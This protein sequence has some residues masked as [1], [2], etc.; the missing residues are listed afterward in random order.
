MKRLKKRRIILAISFLILIVLLMYYEKTTKTDNVQIPKVVQDAQTT[1]HQ[2]I[3]QNDYSIKETNRTIISSSA[4]LFEEENSEKYNFA[5]TTIKEE[6]I[7][8]Y[9]KIVECIGNIEQ[10]Y[11][12]NAETRILKLPQA[13]V[14]SFIQEGWNI[15]ITEYD[16]ASQYGYKKGTVLGMTDYAKSTIFIDNRKEAI[17]TAIEHEFGHY[18]DY[19]SNLPSLSQEFAIIYQEEVHE[20]KAGLSNPNCVTNQQEFFAETF[21]NLILNEEKCTP[22]AKEFVKA[23]INKL[24]S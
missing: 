24:E 23:I 3:E 5:E 19:I 17:E 18:L 20:F 12:D 9:G 14:K 13:I 22:K 16:L 15:Y 7:T 4:N 6:S 21:A 10:Q 1:S 11:I 2:E 8:N